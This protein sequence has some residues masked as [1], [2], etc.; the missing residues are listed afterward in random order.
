MNIS[1]ILLLSIGSV[2][3]FVYGSIITLGW[4]ITRYNRNKFHIACGLNEIELFDLQNM[5]PLNNYAKTFSLTNNTFLDQTGEKIN[6]K[7]FKTYLVGIESS[8][9]P[10]IKRG[11]LIL[12]NPDDNKIVYVFDIPD[13]K[14]YR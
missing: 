9:F 2:F 5:L 4:A 11:N 8:D 7:N 13:L 3:A 12:T 1:P 6:I 14:N 10:K